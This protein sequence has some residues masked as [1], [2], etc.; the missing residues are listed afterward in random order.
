MHGDAGVGIDARQRRRDASVMIVDLAQDAEYTA[1]DVIDVHRR[2][3]LVFV[4][5][6]A[7]RRDVANRRQIGREFVRIETFC[8]LNMSL[9]KQ[10]HRIKI[11]SSLRNMR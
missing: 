4:R 10:M 7:R 6:V 8:V 2:H 11:C 5:R 1:R 3:E 9:K